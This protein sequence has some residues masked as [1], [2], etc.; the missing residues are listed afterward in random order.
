[1]NALNQVKFEPF[2]ERDLEFLRTL[3]QPTFLLKDTNISSRNY[4]LWKNSDLLVVSTLEDGRKW[5][6]LNLVEYVWLHIVRDLRT[7]GIS[8][9]DIKKLKQKILANINSIS[10]ESVE[11]SDVRSSLIDLMQKQYE[12]TKKEAEEKLQE[13]M[14]ES[15]VS[16]LHEFINQFM[17]K[18]MTWLELFLVQKGIRNEE[19]FLIIYLTD[20]EQN[21]KAVMNSEEYVEPQQV[22]ECHIYCTLYEVRPNEKAEREFLFNRPHLQLPLSYYLDRFTLHKLKKSKE[23]GLINE[24]EYKLLKIVRENPG[25]E[26]TITYNKDQPSVL[27]VKTVCTKNLEQELLRNLKK[28]EYCKISYSVEAGKVQHYEKDRKYKLD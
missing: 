27:T 28:D 16:S 17:G 14:K 7:F 1:M 11:E 24:N 18:G 10:K 8:F 4:N 25:K 12:C 23:I 13:A 15:N 5:I 22:L 20:T 9:E 2:T 6:R 21:T 19:S 26:I 3:N